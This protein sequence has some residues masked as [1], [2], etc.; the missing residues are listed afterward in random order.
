M[1]VELTC[2]SITA[3]GSVKSKPHF[4]T[5]KGRRGQ[6][7]EDEDEREKKK[8]EGEKGEENIGSDT[9]QGGSDERNGEENG[10]EEEIRGE[11]YEYNEVGTGVC[12][13]LSPLVLLLFFPVHA[14]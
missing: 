14:S 12:D 9:L 6:K 5:A 8:E 2:I 3:S 7:E 13:I 11:E 1:S 10:D 4:D